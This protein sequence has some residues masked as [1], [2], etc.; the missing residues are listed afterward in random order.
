[1]TQR[2]SISKAAGQRERARL[3]VVLARAQK[4]V[5]AVLPV[6][7]DDVGRDAHVAL[8]AAEVFRL[9]FVAQGK[10]MHDHAPAA[11]KV[12]VLDVEGHATK[13]A[14]L[15]AGQPEEVPQ[16]GQAGQQSAHCA[17]PSP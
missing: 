8:G 10:L 17:T 2:A 7:A 16:T 3:A 12:R 1:V 11:G 13:A 9:H 6:V 4:F 5:A 14:R 15:E